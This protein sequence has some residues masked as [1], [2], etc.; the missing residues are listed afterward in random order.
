MEEKELIHIRRDLHR[1]PELGF[2]EYKTHTYLLEFIK[3]L[4]QDHLTVETWKTG[5]FVKVEGRA[6]KKTIGYRADIDGLPLTEATGY[7]YASTH[8]GKMHACGH[9]F[10][11]TIALAALESLANEPASNHVVFIFQPAEEGPGGAEPMLRSETMK[12]FKPDCIFAL[13]IAPEL[14]AGVVSSRAGLLFANT[15]ELF[16]DLTGKGG[17]AAYPHLTKDMVVAASFLVTQLQQVVARRVDPLDSAVITVGKITGGTVQNIVAEQAR[18]E[19]TIRTMSPEA[20]DRVKA[21]IEKIVEGI[22]VAHDCSAKIDYG[23]NYY[24]VNNHADYVQKFA[25]LT[26]DLN[27]TYQEADAAMTGEDFGYMLKEIP[28]FMFWLGVDSQS[29]LHTSR[30]SPKEEAL[31]IGAKLVAKGLHEL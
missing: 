17:H 13:H 15:S 9:D 22:E 11:M 26:R 3:E 6:P 21:E 28:G 5:I 31:S 29:V 7:E 30:L 25:K 2:E 10:H 12:R 16:I 19:G 1:I 14:P 4:P 27:V 8:E 24:Q 18:L 23:S 20:M